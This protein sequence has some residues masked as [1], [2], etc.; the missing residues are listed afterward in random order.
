MERKNLHEINERI[1]MIVNDRIDPETGEVFEG[2]PGDFNADDLGRLLLTELELDR[3]DKIL[4]CA[5]YMQEHVLEAEKIKGVI[6][7]LKKRMDRHKKDADFLK[8][9]VEGVARDSES[10]ESPEIKVSFRKSIR[11][12]I[13]NEE[14]I[15]KE[16]W[17]VKET[18][19]FDKVLAKKWAKKYGDVP[20]G[21]EEVPVTNMQIK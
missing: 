17:R 8:G 1:Q 12:E 3:S 13:R 20:P 2:E 18:R 16:L 21:V 15:P 6:I 4:H 10:F 5:M 19:T 14:A 7:K 11:M 9:W